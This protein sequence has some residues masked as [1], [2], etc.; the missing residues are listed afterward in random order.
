MSH[1]ANL[2]F[3]GLGDNFKK[4]PKRRNDGLTE[5]QNFV[6]NNVLTPKSTP[7]GYLIEN[8]YN[9][10]VSGNNNKE[11]VVL[12]NSS[13][14]SR[15]LFDGSKTKGPNWTNGTNSSPNSERP[16]GVKPGILQPK[17]PNN[18]SHRPESFPG[19]KKPPLPSL[20][21]KPTE[22]PITVDDLVDH[23]IPAFLVRGTKP[24]DKILIHFHANAENI[25][26]SLRWTTR[27]FQ[28]RRFPMDLLLVEYPGYGF[29]PGKPSQESISDD[30][31]SVI[32]YLINSLNLT[33]TKKI[34]VMG[35]SIGTGPASILA[36]R[37]QLGACILLSPFTSIK[38]VVKNH[39][40]GF[41]SLFIN[42]RFE[43]I[44]AVKNSQSPVI[45]FHGKEDDIVPHCQSLELYNACTSHK[46]MFI[47]KGA[48]HN[49]SEK[50]MD[51][52]FNLLLKILLKLD[53]YFAL[54]AER[55]KQKIIT[56]PRC[57]G[58]RPPGMPRAE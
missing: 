53:P 4:G 20:P 36:S 23:Y 34:Y 5:N 52:L 8:P 56:Y 16:R 1:D 38:E 31:I 12:R 57:I 14:A 9:G 18:Y 35:R 2:G 22:L 11:N 19:Q 3:V 42:Q 44:E 27:F 58:Y 43:N 13:G 7:G 49:F 51:D 17:E 48:T 25:E 28:K 24:K 30:A 54:D 32:E 6:Y 45:F 55:R 46:A 29:Y 26:C 37:Y 21:P 41:L 40:G 39:L 33:D 10:K 50:Q 47:Y 15:G